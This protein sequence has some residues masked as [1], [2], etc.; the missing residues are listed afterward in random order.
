MHPIMA[1]E[2]RA[3]IIYDGE[4]PFC[5][6][7]ARL[8]RLREAV[9]PVEL[10]DAR[11]GGLVVDEVVAA[12]LDLDEGMVLKFEGVFYHGDACLNRLALMST[13]SGVFNRIV[14]TVFSRPAVSRF[15]YPLLRGC[16]NLAL[17][18]LGRSRLDTASARSGAMQRR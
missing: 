4:C 5:S 16:R 18:L 14:A 2:P 12:G 9:G 11:K 15:A 6:A 13:G 8:L 7:Y 1:V 3:V 10:V 17:A